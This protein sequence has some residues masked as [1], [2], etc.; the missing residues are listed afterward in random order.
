MTART[1]TT[2][3]ILLLLL[4]PGRAFAQRLQL[5]GLDGLA[6]Q[7][8]E[9][10]NVTIDPGML[11]L[12]A[13]FMTGQSEADVKA[14]ISGIRGIYIRSFEFDQDVDTSATLES[15]RKQLAAPG[16]ARLVSVDSKRDREAVEIYSWR[17]GDA[18]GGLAIVVSEPMEF[19]VVNIV[20]PIDISKLGALRGLGIPDISVK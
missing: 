6:R 11:K 8:S 18:S 5:D 20:G 3:L 17:E 10:V 13:G 1:T 4:A 12:A 15:L 16:W 14:I 7:A 2:F 19:T 9:S